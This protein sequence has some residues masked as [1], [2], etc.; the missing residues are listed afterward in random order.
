M[1]R[2]CLLYANSCLYYPNVN[3]LLILYAGPQTCKCMWLRDLH[4]AA[5]RELGLI[6]V[7]GVLFP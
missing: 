3:C 5:P 7:N 6:V 4:A 2:S 1:E